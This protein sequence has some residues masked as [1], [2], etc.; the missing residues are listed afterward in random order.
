MTI[1]K[2]IR[3]GADYP[4]LI[5]YL[6]YISKVEQTDLVVFLNKALDFSLSYLD[7]YG[8]T[9]KCLPYVGSRVAC[10]ISL[11]DDDFVK[12]DSYFARF[13]NTGD[14]QF[15]GEFLELLL[16]IYCKF[17]LL[18]SEMDK[19]NVKWFKQQKLSE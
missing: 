6:R 3:I 7:E 14:C 16:Y 4:K 10:S 1:T 2:T 9:F 19:L 15:W 5:E 17:H 18:D 13:K 11:E 12:I 8:M